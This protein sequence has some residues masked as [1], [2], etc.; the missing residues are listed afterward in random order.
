[1]VVAVSGLRFARPKAIGLIFTNMSQHAR[2]EIPMDL[3]DPSEFPPPLPASEAA[4][5]V[6]LLQAKA[7]S[8]PEA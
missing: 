1:M 3:R 2:P 4:D 7:L 5:L 8:Q 6:D